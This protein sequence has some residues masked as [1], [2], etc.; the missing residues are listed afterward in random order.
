LLSS[1]EITKLPAGDVAGGGA[2]SV[3]VAVKF[4]NVG[5][6][7]IRVATGEVVEVEVGEAATDAVWLSTLVSIC[8]RKAVKGG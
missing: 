8:W 2:G 6:G 3:A 7:R 1:R 5:E 4:C